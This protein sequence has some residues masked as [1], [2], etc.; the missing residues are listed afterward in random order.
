MT[1]ISGVIS[2]ID[3]LRERPFVWKGCG[4]LVKIEVAND[5][6]R[7]FIR[8]TAQ[9]TGA[10]ATAIEPRECLDLDLAVTSILHGVSNAIAIAAPAGRLDFSVH[11]E[12]NELW[13]LLHAL[14]AYQLRMQESLHLKITPGVSSRSIN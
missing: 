6:G 4:M 3:W 12:V 5:S 8:L 14:T 9:T 1:E 2:E 11:D 13:R 7:D 10:N